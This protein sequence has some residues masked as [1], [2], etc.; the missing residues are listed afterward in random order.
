[1]HVSPEH[2]P[3]VL[4]SLRVCNRVYGRQDRMCKAGAILGLCVGWVALPRVQR[5]L[6][7]II[8]LEFCDASV[9]YLTTNASECLVLPCPVPCYGRSKVVSNGSYVMWHQN[10]LSNTKPLISSCQTAEDSHRSS[11]SADSSSKPRWLDVLCWESSYSVELGGASS[12][13][14]DSWY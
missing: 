7:W 9:P 10:Q 11:L 4:R 3:D 12:K 6:F 5:V 2:P 13:I 14:I 1:M 8:L